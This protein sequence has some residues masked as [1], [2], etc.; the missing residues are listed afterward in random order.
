MA[1]ML[2]RMY[3]GNPA[4]NLRQHRFLDGCHRQL[5]RHTDTG[6]LDAWP[7]QA[8]YPKNQGSSRMTAPFHAV[9]T[10]RIS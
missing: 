3:I 8:R 6:L 1:R 5:V 2:E 10:V 7:D 4:G 9:A